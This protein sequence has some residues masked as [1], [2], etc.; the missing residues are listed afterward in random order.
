M[1]IQA[2]IG[3]QKYLSRQRPKYTKCRNVVQSLYIEASYK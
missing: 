3:I 1:H 2:V